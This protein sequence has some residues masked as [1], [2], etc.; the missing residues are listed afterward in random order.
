MPDPRISDAE[1]ANINAAAAVREFNI[2]PR[3]DYRTVSAVNGPLVVLDN[4]SFPSYNEIVQLTLPDGS[5]RGGQ[6]L[7]VSGKKAIVQVF[8]GTSGVDTSATRVSFSG[9]SMKLGVSEDML[10]RVFNGSG[11]P[12]DKGPRVWAEDYLDIN[13]SPINPYSRIYPEEM[14]QTGISTIDTMNSI[15]RGQK[16]PIFS[17]AGLPH[18]EI[19]AQICRQAG[20]VKRP[21]ATK[22]V[23]DGH[24]DNFSIVFAAMGVNMETARFFMQDFAE[25]GAISNS[26]LFVNLAS[27]PTIE[28]IITPRLALTTAEYFAYQLEKHVLVVMTDMSSYADALR[29]VSAAREEVPGRRGYPGYLYT[30]LSTIYERAGRVE[31][32]NGSITQVPI[33]TMPNDDITHPI[34]D[35]TGYI[36]E[37]QIFVDRQLH[38][39]QIYPPLSTCSPSLSRLMKSA[40]G[41]KLTRKDHG[42]VSNQLYAKYAVGKDAAS[43]KAVVGEEALSADDKLALEFLD[44]FEHE[45]V[46][47]GAYESR[48][49]FESLDIAWDLL[50]IFPKESLNRISPKILAEFYSRKAKET[51]GKKAT[52]EEDNLIDA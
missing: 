45:F 37:G 35:L 9:S 15:A 29:E 2:N 7:E 52:K 3:L 30:D 38:N 16:I 26:T 42:D 51:S 19:A 21:G 18:N 28:R 27:D 5:V 34:P 46:G 22:S 12:I 25:S 33:L 43:M 32:R 31:G 4:V 1:L 39:R 10:G 6:V 36:T 24:E 41:D 48:T 47:Q 40:I 14:I 17:A 13:G 44:R 8:E 20:L 23:H 11:N 49:I 50:R